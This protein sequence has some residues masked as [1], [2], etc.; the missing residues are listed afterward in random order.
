[1]VCYTASVLGF[2]EFVHHLVFQTKHKIS[3]SEFRTTVLT[4][5]H[6]LGYDVVRLG[7]GV[8]AHKMTLQNTN[9]RGTTLIPPSGTNV[10]MHLPP[11]V[12]RAHH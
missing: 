6:L 9:I 12:R 8:T 10:G 5:V 2:P 7:H 4:N 11:S 3:R 1:M